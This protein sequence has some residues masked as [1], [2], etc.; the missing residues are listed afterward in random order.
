MLVRLLS[1]VGI[2]TKIDNKVYVVPGIYEIKDIS[3]IPGNI[4]YRINTKTSKVNVIH[5]V[6][7]KTTTTNG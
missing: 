2:R 7:A 3:Q 5:P 1:P 4:R 6:T